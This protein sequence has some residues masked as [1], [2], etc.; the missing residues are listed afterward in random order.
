[1]ATTG[2]A[3]GCLILYLISRRAGARAL[4]RFSEAKQ[5]RVKNWIERYDM[6]A[7]LVAIFAVLVATLPSSVVSEVM[8][9]LAS[10]TSTPAVL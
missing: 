10:F 5:A 7:V 1:M 6:F 4:N 3:L 8:L 9:P 2:S